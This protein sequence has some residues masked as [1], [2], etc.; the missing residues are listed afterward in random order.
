[1]AYFEPYIDADGIH[2]PT[3]YDTLEYLMNQYRSIFGEDAYLG[4]ETPDYQLM[5]VFAKCL[6]DYSA[7]AVQA[8]NNRNPNYAVG[9]ALD[10]LVQLSGISRKPA[11]ASTAELTITGE[12]GTVITDGKAI[13]D[14]GNLWALDETYTIPVGGTGTVDSTCET[15]GAI[16]APIGTISGI[17]TPVPGWTS[18][19]NAAVAEK[20]SDIES[21]AELRIRFAASHSMEKNGTLDSFATVLMNI[22]GVKYVS[23]IQND[24]NTDNT[25]SGGLPPHSF[26]AVVDGGDADE[27][28]EEILLLKAPG[29]ATYG[30]T[31]KTVVD[32]YGN[33]NTIKFSRPT[34]TTVSVTVNITPLSGYD[35]TRVDA[36]IKEAL[37]ADINSLGIGKSWSVSLG[38]KDIYTQF[39]SSDLPFSIT[40]IASSTASNGV[41]SCAYDHILQTDAS[42]ITIVTPT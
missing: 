32:D 29:V 34:T 18:V 19:T 27:I 11:T 26:C 12:A 22:A 39:D 30:S 40:S 20:G 3:Y 9:D 5:S 4:E 7:L 41:V 31:T 8:Y 1:M 23:V 25:G 10:T 21:D 14:Q 37:I 42:H 15:L 13:D 28:A 38:Y 35:A 16:V 33:S 17:Y 36:I 2:I 6:D 24:T